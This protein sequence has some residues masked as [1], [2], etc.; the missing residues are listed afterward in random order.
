MTNSF[1]STSELLKVKQWEEHFQNVQFPSDIKHSDAMLGHVLSVFHSLWWITFNGN[2]I[3]IKKKQFLYHLVW[4]RSKWV[5]TTKL[6]YRHAEKLSQLPINDQK[7]SQWHRPLGWPCLPSLTA[8]A[9]GE[10]CVKEETLKISLRRLIY[11]WSSK[12]EQ[13]V[14]RY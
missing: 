10:I 9:G 8:E 2:I 1:S 7:R 5:H 4:Y 3:I 14:E 13:S 11:K 6:I 12:R